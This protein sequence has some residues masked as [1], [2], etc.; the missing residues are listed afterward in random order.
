M[1]LVRIIAKVGVNTGPVEAHSL[2]QP[3]VPRIA[4][5]RDWTSLAVE[6]ST[7]IVVVFH[8][9]EIRQHVR[10]GPLGVAPGGPGIIIL[11]NAP[12]QHLPIDGTRT[13]GRLA[14]RDGQPVLLRRE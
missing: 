4:A 11:R 3:L 12:V 14:T 1:V 9:A 13:A 5:Y 6:C 2:R 10:I 7:K 8:R